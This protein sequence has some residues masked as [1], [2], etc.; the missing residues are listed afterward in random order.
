V[1]TGGG[2][3]SAQASVQPV[4][5]VQCQN[6]EQ[7]AVHYHAH[8]DILYKNQPVIIP[9][10]TGI[11]AGGSCLY[12]LHTHDETGI[13][14]IEAPKPQANRKFTLGDFFAV[15]RQPLSRSKV[16][17]IPVG[18][19]NDLKVWVNGV[20]YAGD[21]SK[22]VLTEKEQVVLEI[23]P[24]YTDPPPTFNWPAGL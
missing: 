19:G 18:S 3:N 5:S 12:W 16:A 8:V 15:W 7:L 9:A 22:I 20:P 21:P 23:G 1:Q 2:T 10:N 17:T 6:G 24:P 11:P 13:I 14:H 4:A